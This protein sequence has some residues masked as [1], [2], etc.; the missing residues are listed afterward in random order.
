MNTQPKDATTVTKA[1]NAK[2]LQQ[3]PFADRR[4][5]EEADRGF[6]APLPNDGLIK[7]DGRV[8]W[9]L[10][11][12]NFIKQDE[13]APDTVNPSLWRQS[14]LVIKGGLYKVVDRLYQVRTADLSNLTIVEGDTGIIIFD[15]LISAE[16]ARAALDLYYEHRPKKPVVA[17]VHSHSHADHYGGV[18]GVVSEEDVKA[19]KVMILAPVGFLRAAVAENVLAGNVMSRRASY[20]YGNLLPADP[21]GQVGAGLGMTTSNGTITLIPP[22][23]E[24]T[25]TGQKMNIDGLDFEFLLAPDTEAPAE[26]HWY[27]EQLKALTAAENCCHTLHNTYSMRGTSCR[28]PQAWAKYLNQTID[29]WGDKAEVMYGMHHWPVWGRERILEMLEKGRDGYRYINDQTLRLANHGYTPVEIAEQVEFPPEL[30]N[31]WAMRPYYGTLNHNVKATYT[32]YLGWFDGNPATLYTLPPE[33]AAKKYVA[34]MGGADKV[35]EGATAAFADGEYRW[36]AEVV[37][38]VV[39][40]D[41][42]HEAARELLAD[43]FEQ[44]GYQS[45]AGPWRNFYLTGAKE[46]REGVKQLPAPNTASPDSVRAMSLDLFF[47]YLGV[48]LNGPKAAGKKI[49]IN[50]NFTD[51]GE[52]DVIIL[53]NAALNH[54]PNRQDPSADATLTLTRTALNNIILQESTLNEEIKNGEVQVV[55]SL[56]KVQELVS[57]LD[58][59]EFWFNIVTP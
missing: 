19:G 17:V 31:H 16:T 47:D 45:E 3:L 36:V 55:G 56:D 57:L 20:M 46:L 50:L 33:E 51:T 12:F 43:A 44:L 53:K 13:P 24:I 8:V 42:E 21:K 1:A 41:P 27:I 6:I 28:D 15:P 38:H 5:F 59:F 30:A 39:F 11:R 26:M 7:A 48:R 32:K 10:T 54:S 4:D 18:R 58:S 22:T 49:S 34:M 37:K 25:E 29:M 9:D 52:K 35:V 14:Q 40:A 23:H 2:L